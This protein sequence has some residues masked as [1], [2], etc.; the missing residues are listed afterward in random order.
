MI[1]DDHS[2]LD[3]VTG[4]QP[5][6]V[7]A[8]A[9]R[10]G[11]FEVL[12]GVPRSA[13]D[14]AREISADPSN[15]AALLDALTSLGLVDATTE[16]YS[17]TS[18]AARRLGRDGE[19]ALVVAKEAVFA[20]AWT[21]LDRVVLEGRPAMEPWRSQL[22]TDPERAL[23]FLEALDVLARIGG[24]P[25]HELGALAPGRRVLDVGGGLGAYSRI[26]DAAGS[27]VTLVDLPPVAAWAA[28]RLASTGV[29]VVAVD[30]FEH[31]SCGVAPASKDAALVSH[32]LHDLPR[33]RGIDLLRRVRNTLV[34]EGRVV[35]N[36]FAADS[37]PGAFGALFDVM[38]RV[39]TGGAAHSR[40]TLE[41][42]LG[43]AGFAGVEPL[44]YEDPLTLYVG[45]RP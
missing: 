9:Q 31:P 44:P 32:L 39:E 34:S 26:L 12:P 4:Y 22:E 1:D 43:E 19:M 7:I 21:R 42:M 23:A 24:P 36:D 5:P 27:E 35:V 16:G 40:A 29:S 11:L 28:D 6:A 25:L 41:A 14:L 18:Y 38:M 8:A 30:L 13:E 17:A 20:E 2:L 45:T 37:G 10:I 33:E 15:L 3:L